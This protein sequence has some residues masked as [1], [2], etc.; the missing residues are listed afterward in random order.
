MVGEVAW[1]A[2]RPWSGPTVNLW[3]SIYTVWIHLLGNSQ[4]RSMALLQSLIGMTW[5]TFRPSVAFAVYIYT[6]NIGGGS[7]AQC[8]VAPHE[9]CLANSSYVPSTWAI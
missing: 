7:G 1:A 4:C 8:L 5:P 3:L 9:N 6:N 2:I